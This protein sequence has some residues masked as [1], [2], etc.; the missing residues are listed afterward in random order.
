MPGPIRRIID[1]R[2]GV[3]KSGDAAETWSSI[4]S[5]LDDKSTGLIID[6]ESPDTVYAA[7]VYRSVYKTVTGGR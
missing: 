6:P 7:T 5:G 1:S 2:G 4:S 3:H